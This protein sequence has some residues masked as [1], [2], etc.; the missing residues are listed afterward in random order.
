MA[1][2]TTKELWRLE[3]V[4]NGLGTISVEKGPKHSKIAL[5]TMESSLIGCQT[6]MGQWFTRMGHLIMANFSM[7][8]FKVKVLWNLQTAQLTKAN[9]KMDSR[10]D[11]AGQKAKTAMF[12][13]ENIWTVYRMVRAKEFSRTAKHTPEHSSREWSRVKELLCLQ[14]EIITRENSAMV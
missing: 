4:R 6:V 7:V 14:M 2:P 9:T 5:L 13:R 1:S 11:K 12:L 10:T 8:S 3:K